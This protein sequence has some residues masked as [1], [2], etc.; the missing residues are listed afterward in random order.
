MAGT[1]WGC[2]KAGTVWGCLKA[3]TCHDVVFRRRLRG[4]L[5]MHGRYLSPGKSVDV[6]QSHSPGGVQRD[7]QQTGEG[8]DS[9]VSL[10]PS[11]RFPVCRLL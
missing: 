9:E 2:L 4:R 10:V 5:F 1:V 8:L 6:W 11:P 7:V 3:G